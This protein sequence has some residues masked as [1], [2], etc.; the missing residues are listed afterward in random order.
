MDLTNI[1]DDLN[2]QNYHYYQSLVQ[3]GNPIEREQK[4]CHCI[5]L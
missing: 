1:G 3:N 2:I 4:K 5:Q